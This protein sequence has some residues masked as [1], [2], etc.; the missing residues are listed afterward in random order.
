MGENLFGRKEI[1]KGGIKVHNSASGTAS[2]GRNRLLGRGFPD[3]FFVPLQ[4]LGKPKT[5]LGKGKEEG[6][7]RVL[8]VGDGGGLSWTARF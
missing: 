7:Y 2:K 5:R 8:I 1:L 6:D 3:E 4:G